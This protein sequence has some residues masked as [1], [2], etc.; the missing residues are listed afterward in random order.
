MRKPANHKLIK[1]LTD[2]D[3]VIAVLLHQKSVYFAP[4]GKV[5]PT[6]FFL[7]WAWMSSEKF[8]NYISSGA[9][10]LAEK[11]EDISRRRIRETLKA[12]AV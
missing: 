3:S 5:M 10:Y 12:I 11:Y 1:S 2:T 4:A 9:F 7:G 8:M 6:K